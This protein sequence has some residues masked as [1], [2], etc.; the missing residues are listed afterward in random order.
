MNFE[1]KEIMDPPSFMKVI[2]FNYFYLIFTNMFENK[3][4]FIYIYNK[5][6][7]N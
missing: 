7:M 1:E 4:K 2:N 5:M 6:P 3:M